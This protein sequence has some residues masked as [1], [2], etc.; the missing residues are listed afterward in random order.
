MV[1]YISAS[2]LNA[3]KIVVISSQGAYYHY[4]CKVQQEYC[5]ERKQPEPLDNIFNKQIDQAL[6][7]VY[8]YVYSS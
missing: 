2:I 5:I 1:D 8:F 3:D 4:R 7:Y 6:A